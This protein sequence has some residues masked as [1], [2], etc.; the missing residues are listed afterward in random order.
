[1]QMLII[2]K[3]VSL[4]IMSIIIQYELLEFRFERKKTLLTIGVSSAVVL[5][6]NA[7][8]LMN[9]ELS[10]FNKL[11]PI[12]FNLPIFVVIAYLSRHRGFKVLFNFFTTIFI[13]IL[14]SAVGYFISLGFHQN[15]AL[16]IVGRFIG[17]GFAY[18][19]TKK[20]LRP[21][22][23]EMVNKLNEGWVYLCLIPLLF[24]LLIYFS[25]GY[26]DCISENISRPI[27]ITLSAAVVLAGYGVIFIFFKQIQQYN[28]ILE[29]KIEERTK[30][31]FQKNREILLMDDI[32]KETSEG[33][34]ITDENFK[35]IKV[36]EA[37][38]NMTGYDLGEIINQDVK[39]FKSGR[40]E[41]SFYENMMKTLH[42]EDRWS[43][44]I[45]DRKKDGRLY[46]KRTTI[47]II[48]DE[49]NKITNYVG[50]CSDIT[51]LKESEKQLEN[52]AFYDSLTKLPNRALFY[53]RLEQAL[54]R[55]ERKDKKLALFFMDL[56]G[57]K[58]INDKYGHNIGDKLLVEVSSRIKNKIRKSD[59]LA[60]LG[61]DE[62]TAIFEEINED[63]DAEKLAH[64]IITEISEIKEVEGC[65]MKV[66]VS[67]GIVIIN[68]NASTLEDLIKKADDAMY[69][70]KRKGKGCYTL[71]SCL[72]LKLE[73][74]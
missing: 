46:A 37:F 60:R 67:I 22:Y 38:C 49:N 47:D 72:Q 32:F 50:I 13:C 29:N 61:G 6:V 42:L 15:I 39:L 18:I 44:E 12:I 56:D 33:I 9:G 69:L 34:V 16:S 68:N 64:Q 43:G 51:K 23:F 3:E 58:K 45:W 73:N 35:I 4:L 27:L 40:H 21:I 36:N 71:E 7:V 2:I 20:F 26:K 74:C 17:F 8:V 59:T 11:F 52:M 24:S 1:M 10:V 30:E 28:I 65:L 41:Y 53:E 62:F 54:I 5:I 48:R 70:S 57:F 31:L 14:I 25:V 55:L 66:G 63:C 19:F